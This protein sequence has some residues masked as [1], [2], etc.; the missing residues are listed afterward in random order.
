MMKKVFIISSV[1]DASKEFKT[2]LE[3]YV[4][5][6]ESLGYIL[7]LPH[8][9]TNQNNTGY[10]ICKENFEAIKKSDEVHVFYNSKSRCACFQKRITNNKLMFLN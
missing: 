6:L 9:D 4:Q 1:R 7:H 3:N 5:N 10:E 8:R 2:K